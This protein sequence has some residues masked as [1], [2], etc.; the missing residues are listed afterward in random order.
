MGLL[1]PTYQGTI[2]LPTVPADFTDRIARRVERGLFVPGSRRRANYVVS[3]KTDDSIEFNAVGFW[4]VY[5]VGLNN[6]LLQREGTNAIAY[7]GKFWRWTAILVTHALV[8]SAAI[9]MV[10]LLLPTGRE[11]VSAYSWGWPYLLTLLAFFA[12]V[13][14]WVGVALHRRF[15]AR[16]LERIVRETVTA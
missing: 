13:F 7:H 12:L 9:L 10:V 8:I 16:A 2:K 11:M 1:S 5:N 14:P 6:V 15:A 3:A 4:T